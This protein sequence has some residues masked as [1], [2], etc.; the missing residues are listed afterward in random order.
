MN[1]VLVELI[2]L[3]CEVYL[4]DM[5]VYG[6]N[7]EEYVMNL[8]LVFKN[9][10]RYK[11]TINS[12]KCLFGVTSLEFLGHTIDEQGI[13]LARAKLDNSVVNFADIY[14]CETIKVFNKTR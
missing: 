3:I 2:F 8:R 5:L 9:F 4:D 1:I 11:I 10:L 13:S 7:A 14:K 6:S 12:D